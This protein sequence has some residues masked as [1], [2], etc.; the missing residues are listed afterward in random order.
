MKRRWTDSDGSSDDNNEDYV[1]AKERRRRRLAR[2]QN[3]STGTEPD[4]P[5]RPPESP[6]KE[7]IPKEASLL[8]QSLRGLT[9]QQSNEDLAEVSGVAEY[10]ANITDLNVSLLANMN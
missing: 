6:T 5:I 8:A 4:K 2:I 1:T 7:S 3:V 10:Y 9:P